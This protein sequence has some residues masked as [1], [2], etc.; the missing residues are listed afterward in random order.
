MAF[1]QPDDLL[2]W[3]YEFLSS[4]LP[5][6]LS[7]FLLSN[8]D[9]RLRPSAG[10]RGFV[11]LFAVY[12]TGVYHF[13]GAG[14]LYEGLRFLPATHINFNLIPFSHTIDP[15]GYVLNVVLFVPLGLL[16]P[17]LWGR[18]DRF[19]SVLGI[20]AGFSLFLELSQLL[21]ARA[22]D[23]DDLILNTAGAVLGFAAYRLLAFAARS[24]VQPGDLPL[25]LLALCIFIPY[26]GR[27]F[28]YDAMGLARLLYGF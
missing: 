25:S 19:L 20:G 16:V 4:L 8:L 7:W 26:L 18:A 28:L 2:F 14:T 1:P 11:L 15:G 9:R 12:I 21:N 22:S 23:V 13:T 10:S 24:R 17:F 27:F 5:F 6:L 3:G